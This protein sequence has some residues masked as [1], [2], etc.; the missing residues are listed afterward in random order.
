MVVNLDPSNVQAGILELPWAGP[1]T[2]ADVLTGERYA[3]DGGRAFILLDPAKMPAHVLVVSRAA[4]TR[5]T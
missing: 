2:V 5:G 1:V 3:W 4:L